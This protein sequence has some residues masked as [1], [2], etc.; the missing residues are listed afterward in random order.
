[1]T[2][3]R[4]RLLAFAAESY[5]TTH[6]PQGVLGSMAERSGMENYK[7]ALATYPTAVRIIIQLG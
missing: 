1:M 2:P 4:R 3:H 7:D 6:N 5:V